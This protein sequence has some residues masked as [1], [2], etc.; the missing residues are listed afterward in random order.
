MMFKG[1]YS[2]N[3]QKPK[4]S[5][6]AAKHPDVHPVLSAEALLATEKRQLHI[7]NIKSLLNLPPKLYDSLYHR[8]IQQ[9]AEFSQNLP[10]TRYGT[11][12][13]AGGFLDHGLERAARALSLCLTYFFPQEKTFQNVSSQ[14][15]L[16]LYAVFT[17]ALLL[18][19]GK[20][21][22]KFEVELCNKDG[23]IIK[24]WLPYTGPMVG[25][26]KFYRYDYI[27]RNLDNL[28][29]LITGLIARQILD[30]P[31]ET[32][33]TSGF[34]W[35]ASNHDVLETW[36]TILQ[37]ERRLPMTSFMSMIPL[38]E[39]QIIEHYLNNQELPQRTTH[40]GE[41]PLSKEEKVSE[42]LDLGEEFLQWVR[43]KLATETI[44]PN[45]EKSAIQVVEE[46]VLIDP[47][48]IQDFINDPKRQATKGYT[49]SVDPGSVEQQF[50]QYVEAFWDTPA[51]IQQRHILIKG[52]AAQQMNR[53][54]LVANRALL[55]PPGFQS[56]LSPYIAKL[57]A[58][59]AALPQQPP[60]VEAVQST[61]NLTFNA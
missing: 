11:F 52:V 9:F 18:D 56:D 2:T 4:P 25:Q 28:K 41:I 55:F 5:E 34:D 60:R 16:W 17:A 58:Q 15:A 47:K 44:T 10:E 46:G 7:K 13:N 57:P 30:Q 36:L 19:I 53:F 27:K 61:P 24:E 40:P 3:L 23:S 39:A 49:T 1:L 37:G 21:G 42:K 59:T 20:I 48:L 29:R 32:P 8:V 12:A 26:A 22:V 35:I 51:T 50:R 38:A 45:E 6:T 43:D 54:I 31:N 33:G 14:E